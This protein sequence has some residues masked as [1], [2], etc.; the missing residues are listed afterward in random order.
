MIRP[1][2]MD[3]AA[4]THVTCQVGSSFML[5][6]KIVSISFTLML[7]LST[8][9]GKVITQP[10]LVCFVPFYLDQRTVDSKE[11]AR[12]HTRRKPLARQARA[13]DGISYA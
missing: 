6:E 7:T 9:V 12:R 2:I 10:R 8:V 5:N 4:L 13:A 11:E 3:L 1:A